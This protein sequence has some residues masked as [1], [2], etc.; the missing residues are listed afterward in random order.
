MHSFSRRAHTL[1]PGGAL[2]YSRG[3]DVLPVNAPAAFVRGKGSHVWDIDGRE[4][5][6]WGMG[7]NNVLIGHAEDVIDDAAVAALREGQAFTRPSP[8]ELDAAEALLSFFPGMEMVKFSKNGSD[9]NSAAIRLARAITG[10]DMIA[11][12]G[13]APFLSI[14]DWFIGTTAMHAGVPGA[15]RALSAP[16][17]Y[18]DLA[19]VERV[20]AEHPGQVAAVILEVC[21][22]RRPP[23]EFLPGVRALCDREGA[24]LIFDEVVTGFRYHINGAQALFGVVPDLM[25]VGKGMANGYALAALLGRRA[26]MER[27]GTM[28]S[29]PRVFLLSTTNGPERSGLAAGLAVMQFYRDHDVIGALAAT[30]RAVRDGLAEVTAD[31]GIGAYLFFAGEFDNRPVLTCL[32]PRGSASFE[33]RTL[34]LQELLRSGVFMPWVCPSYRHT[35]NDIERTVEAFRAAV[36]VYVRALTAGSTAGM[37]GGRP[38]KTVFREFN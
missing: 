27:G 12:D 38:V 36:P 24:L 6:D 2:T 3:D 10:R 9:P 20:F 35:A 23:P 16:F 19:S 8:L 14:H 11:F 13:S 34:F 7:I 22:E 30:G 4:F 15:I 29:F 21:R 17:R 18:G 32:D 31:A 37:V 26:Y 1:I 25:S 5:I 28:H 33:F